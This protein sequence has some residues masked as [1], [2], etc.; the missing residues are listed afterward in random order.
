MVDLSRIVRRPPRKFRHKTI[1]WI[2]LFI[3]ETK[4]KTDKADMSLK[5]ITKELNDLGR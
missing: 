5:R 1:L 4:D 3:E 2:V